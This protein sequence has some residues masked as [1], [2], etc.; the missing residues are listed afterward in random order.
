MAL[1]CHHTEIS[2]STNAKCIYCLY[3]PNCFFFM[4]PSPSPEAH[5][6]VT[7]SPAITAPSKCPG[8]RL[9][10]LSQPSPHSQPQSSLA[11]ILEKAIVI[12][13]CD[14]SSV[15]FSPQSLNR[16]SQ[17]TEG[18][19]ALLTPRPVSASQPGTLKASSLVG[20]L[21]FLTLSHL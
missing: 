15:L 2:N 3:P 18:E 17:A 7:W 10:P 12:F 5:N 13:D 8:L 21:Q 4:T 11:G 1:P 20:Y 19:L 9:P 6:P 14:P 16:S